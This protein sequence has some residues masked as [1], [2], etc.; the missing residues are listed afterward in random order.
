MHG[1]E[2]QTAIVFLRRTKIWDAKGSRVDSQAEHK[3]ILV[4]FTVSSDDILAP[5][6][7]AQTRTMRARQPPD[8]HE[9]LEYLW[10]VVLLFFQANFDMAMVNGEQHI[11]D[12][13]KNHVDHFEVPIEKNEAVYFWSFFLF[14]KSLKMLI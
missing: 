14:Y 10:Q 3:A 12:N 1:E 11:G 7:K 2:I 8:Y 5:S 6:T 9:R 4:Q 13:E